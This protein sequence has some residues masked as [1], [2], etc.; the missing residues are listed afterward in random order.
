MAQ[1]KILL[2]GQGIPISP[3]YED[4]SK[5]Y[6]ETETIAEFE[7]A[8]TR[9][10]QIK[11]EQDVDEDDLFELEYEDG[12][13]RI[14]TLEQLQKEGNIKKTREGSDPDPDSNVITV[15]LYLKGYESTSRGIIKNVLKKL[16]LIKPNEAVAGIT[17]LALAKKIESRLEPGPGLYHCQNPNKLGKRAN[18]ILIDRPI[19]ILLHG[20]SSS[21]SGSFGGFFEGNNPSSAWKDILEIYDDRIF[22]FEHSTLTKSPLLNA[23]ELLE[24]LPKDAVVHFISHSR[25]GLIGE[26][27]SRNLINREEAFSE[28]EINVFEKLKRKQEVRYLN[29][30][31]ALLREKNIRVDKF[32]RVA[33]PASGT[34]LASQ[35]LDIYLTVILNLIGLI[36]ALK[37]NPIYS[38]VK[39]FLM[40]FVKKKEDIRVFPGLEAMIPDSPLI[41]VLN[42]PD[43]KIDSELYILAGDVK[44]HGILRSLQVLVADGFFRTQHDFVVNTISMF[45][46]ARRDKTYY[47]FYSNKE[48]SHFRYFS[49]TT[50]QN[51][52]AAALQSYEQLPI[53]FK[54]FSQLIR[55]DGTIT[56]VRGRLDYVAPGERAEK[57]APVVYVLPGIM[58]SKLSA[59]KDNIWVNPFRL[60]SGQME[61]LAIDSP[62]VEAHALMGS[63][64]RSL[65][66][67]LGK[68]YNVVPFP[69]DWRKSIIESAMELTEDLELRMSK[70]NRPIR[71]MAHS[72]GGLVVHAMYSGHE[73]TWKKFVSREGSRAIFL[74]S[75]LRGS[76]VIPSLFLRK[77]RLFKTLH[78]LDLTN[79]S[80]ELLKII[81]S[82]P[83]L[84]EL[85][86]IDAERDYNDKATWIEMGR[87]EEDF[88]L[89]L[90]PELEKARKLGDLF[91]KRPIKGENLIYVA[92]KDLYTPYRMEFDHNNKATLWGT[93]KGDS[94]VTWETGI[95]EAFKGRTWYM[96]ATHGALCATKEYFPALIEL[97]EFGSTSLLPNQPIMMRGEEDD[98]VMP[99]EYPLISPSEDILEHN[100]MGISSNL[101]TDEEEVQITVQVCHGDLGNVKYPVAVGHHFNDPIV[102]A[103]RVVDYYMNSRLSQNHRVGMYPGKLETSLTLLCK[104]S[105]FKGALVLG[106]GIYGELNQGNLAKTFRHAFI[107]YVMTKIQTVKDCNCE[108]KDIT[109]E[110]MGISSLLVASDYSGLTIRNSI[111]A[112]LTGVLEANKHL[113][114]INSINAPQLVDVEII[115]IY[116]DRAINAMHELKKIIHEPDFVDK[117]VLKSSYV[118]EVP[119]KR[120]RISSDEKKNWWHRLKVETMNQDKSDDMLSELLKVVKD[121]NEDDEIRSCS[122][123][124]LMEHFLDR[125]DTKQNP[126]KFISLTDRARAEEQIKSTQRSLIDRLIEASVRVTTWD[127]ETARTLFHLLIPNNFK[128]YATD[129]KNILLI[130]DEQSASYPWEILHYPNENI[131]LPIS[132]Q[133]GLIR[134]LVV[135]EYDSRVNQTLID[136]AYVIGNPRLN[137]LLGFA[138]LPN[139]R[140][141]GLKVVDIL[142]QNGYL[143]TSAIEEDSIATINKLFG[144]DYK[145]IH[146]AGHGVVSTTDAAKSGMVLD[147]DIF[148]TA[149]EID[150]LSQT[151]EFVFINCCYLGKTSDLGTIPSFHK[152]AAN[153]GTQFIRK[154][155]KAVIAGGWAVDDDAALG[156]AESFY[157]NMFNGYTFGES[158]K[159][160]RLETYRKYGSSNTWGAYQCYGDPFYTF[161]NSKKKSDQRFARYVDKDEVLVDLDNLVNQ[162]EPASSRDRGNLKNQ[163]EELVKSI[164]EHWLNDSRILEAIG[165]FYYEQNL[166]EEA[167][168]YLEKLRLIPDAMYS[169]GSLSKLANIQTKLA[170]KDYVSTGDFFDKADKGSRINKAEQIIGYLEGIGETHK[171]FSLKGGHYK[172][173]SLTQSS[174]DYVVK[175]LRT[176]ANAYK[177]AHE[178]LVEIEPDYY[179]IINWLTI[180][181]ISELIGSPKQGELVV[182]QKELDEL[183]ARFEEKSENSDSFWTLTYEGAIG[184]YE[185]MKKDVSKKTRKNTVLKVRDNYKKHWCN[186]GSIRKSENIL[187]QVNFSIL[188]LERLLTFGNSLPKSV[189]KAEVK[190]IMASYRQL[191]EALKDVFND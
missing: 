6:F 174:L 16:K 140:D 33:C 143:T 152:L 128:D 12:L 84:L 153:V 154:G 56:K 92:G 113:K 29:R 160:A 61:R 25:G 67:A 41:R 151:P 127:K 159:M 122:K 90:K 164:P 176:A 158:V 161:G 71:I 21:T 162:V 126:L 48:I 106:L 59:E 89:P 107:D 114:N 10:K 54:P 135:N 182:A 69:F 120:R 134:Q 180:E 58:G 96:R 163:V 82:Y 32:V 190:E 186:G 35:R 60:A 15:P 4:S 68:K 52:I 108:E 74:G 95:P 101:E 93:S 46:S 85:L 11:I 63:A 103:E 133:I 139:A 72:M 47:S 76:H 66:K 86:P 81:R 14:L 3:L 17:A 132:T 91:K 177:R 79:D 125:P 172:R 45:G 147:D 39:A 98:F 1:K 123:R 100:I 99:E 119:G 144:N 19:L 22:A 130:V 94:C 26:I 131:D 49:H 2:Y 109:I 146:M 142:A 187:G 166:Y 137:P 188:I 183:Y 169:L 189:D 167:E 80:A 70:T 43:K 110:D 44:A 65:L 104:D 57:D 78:T 50:S 105:K 38:F 27:L 115:E 62:E 20:T 116:K 181:R 156:F 53:G 165:V 8:A 36:P 168:L 155:V 5:K 77:H 175:D 88:V 30:I 42:N 13:L 83:G 173:K 138:N 117:V 149:A 171:H 37:A 157:K 141:E 40:A 24:E 55:E 129:N 64:Y 75:P 184:I 51:N 18:N 73:S 23:I 124:L 28:V 31:N 136:S 7:I 121:A 97:L 112:L 179:S 9:A 118:N 191:Y 111:R 170:L 145:I 102:S 185:V 178:L 34:I 150:S 87:N 148:I